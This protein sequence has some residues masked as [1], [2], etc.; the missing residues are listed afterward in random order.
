MFNGGVKK[1]I[2]I[3]GGNLNQET[4]LD[5]VDNYPVR[6]VVRS[7]SRRQGMGAREDWGSRRCEG[8]HRTEAGSGE[9]C[10]YLAESL[11]QRALKA[12]S[13]EAAKLSAP[14]FSTRCA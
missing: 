14:R 13:Y 7:A 5:V 6:K 11:F 10:S 4:A 2:S 1:E 12:A 3:T 8:I 9:R